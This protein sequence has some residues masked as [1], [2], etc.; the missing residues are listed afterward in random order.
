MFWWWTRVHEGDTVSACAL[1]I[2]DRRHVMVF[3]DHLGEVS[4]HDGKGSC[5]W[6]I[7]P[8]QSDTTISARLMSFAFIDGSEREASSST[9]CSPALSP[10]SLL[11]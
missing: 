4:F 2:N 7:E 5:A 3:I 10:L 6:T 8:T 1:T 11:N 9:R